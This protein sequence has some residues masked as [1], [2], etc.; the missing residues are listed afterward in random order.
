MFHRPSVCKR[1]PTL[2]IQ[3]RISGSKAICFFFSRKKEKSVVSFTH[4]HNIICSQTQLDD[5]TLEQTI[6]CRQLF[7]GHVMGFRPMKRKTNLH[8]MIIKLIGRGWA[9]YRDL[10]VQVASRSIICQ[11]RKKVYIQDQSFNNFENNTSYSDRYVPTTKDFTYMR[12]LFNLFRNVMN[13]TVI[14]NLCFS[15]LL[16]ITAVPREIETMLTKNLAEGGVGGK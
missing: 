12:A 8:Q 3:F 11:S 7:A 16:G 4:E 14:H 5:I 6:I 13:Q 15:F 10:S 9:K 2:Q 1:L